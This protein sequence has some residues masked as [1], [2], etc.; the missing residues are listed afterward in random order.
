MATAAARAREQR[1]CARVAVALELRLGRKVGNDVMA[2]SHDLSASGARVVTDRPLRIDEE[3]E[4]A[5]DLPQGAHLTGTARVLRQHRHDMY[6]LR[7]EQVE[8][9]AHGLLGEFVD[10]SAPRN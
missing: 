8:P 9:E 2:R 3:L 6:A 4:F 5:F 10:A 7:F 1:G